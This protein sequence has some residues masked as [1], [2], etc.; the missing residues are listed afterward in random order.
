M[1][2]ILRKFYSWAGNVTT[3]TSL[4]SQSTLGTSQLIETRNAY[5]RVVWKVSQFWG[6]EIDGKVFDFKKYLWK[7]H[8]TRSELHPVR[9]R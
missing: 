2:S 3:E 9:L 7:F 5:K 1:N 4:S 8:V 6:R